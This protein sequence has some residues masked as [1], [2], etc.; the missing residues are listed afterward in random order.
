LLAL[1]S[2]TIGSPDD[3]DNLFVVVH[4]VFDELPEP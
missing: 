3:L 2:L 4:L 1:D